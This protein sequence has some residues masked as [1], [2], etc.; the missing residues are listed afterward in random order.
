M[1]KQLI[2]D[3]I[4]EMIRDGEVSVTVS[5]CKY[6]WDSER[7]MMSFSD[8]KDTIIECDFKLEVSDE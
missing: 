2:K 5:S 4:K 3:V 1:D 6:C 8:V 7:R